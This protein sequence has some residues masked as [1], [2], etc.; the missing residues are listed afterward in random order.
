MREG[1]PGIGGVQAQQRGRVQRDEHAQAVGALQPLAA[2]L[3]DGHRVAQQRARRGG[4]QRHRGAWAHQGD[5]VLEPLAAGGGLLLA[6][7]LVQPALA[8]QLVLEMLD[9]VGEVQ[10]LGRPAQLRQRAPQQ[11]AGR[12]HEGLAAQVFLVAGLLADQHQRRAALSLAVHGLG[13]VQR[14][15]ILRDRWFIA[16]SA[17]GLALLLLW[18]IGLL[19]PA[20]VPMG[21]GQ[22]LDRLQ[23]LIAEELQG[24]PWADWVV[25]WHDS[26]PLMVPLSR[27]TEMIAVMLGLL[28][29]CLVAF[30]VAQPGWRRA[31]LAVGAIGLGLATTTLSTALNFGP[32]HAMTWVTPAVYPACVAALVLALGVSLLP[33]RAAAGLGLV[34]LTAMVALVDQAP[35]DPYYAESLHGWEQGR[36]I[37]FHG[38]A[39]WVGWLWPY[40]AMAYL[41]MRLGARDAPR[42]PAA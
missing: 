3:A 10:R 27:G 19:F 32:Q 37:R 15:Q 22:V 18:P 4:T 42:V 28:A 39:Q 11:L 13:G 12:A 25:D 14:W 30:A 35:A 34:V 29:P 1:R 2:G 8:A 7:G 40:V 41:L 24:T 33:R 23:A 21:L 16:R 5:L 36:F 17:G 20:P 6:G 9:G 31:V 38:L 26:V